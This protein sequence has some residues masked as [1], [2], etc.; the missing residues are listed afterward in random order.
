MSES[1]ILGL[2]GMMALLLVLAGIGGAVDLYIQ[3]QEERKHR[4]RC[5]VYPEPKR[6]GKEFPDEME[7]ELALEIV[8]SER[9]A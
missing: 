7:I 3:W 8:N 4:S 9:S 1:I 6:R 2:I 5:R